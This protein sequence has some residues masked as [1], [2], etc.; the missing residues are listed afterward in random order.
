[1]NATIK[2]AIIL[3]VI[4]LIAAFLLSFVN[5]IT[6]DV[7]KQNI[8]KKQEVAFRQIFTEADSFD[9]VEIEEENPFDVSGAFTSLKNNVIEGYLFNVSTTGY[10]GVIN[11]VIGVNADGSIKGLQL[12][13]HTETKGL[14]T[15]AEEGF[16]SQY[17][18]RNVEAFEVVSGTPS[19]DV[20]VEA[21]SGAT[22][23]SK[24][25]TAGVNNALSIFKELQGG[26]D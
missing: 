21:I 16:L 14:G 8:I 3:C 12:I 25:V 9:I 7:I 22:V 6:S 15:S 5:G 4:S 19:S 11:M 23:S 2:N 26:L 17:I 1:M 10:G 13:G 18:D 24:A 20:Q